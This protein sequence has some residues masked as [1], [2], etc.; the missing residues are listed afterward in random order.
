MPQVD[1]ALLSS[2]VNSF[3]ERVDAISATFERIVGRISPEAT[4]DARANALINPIGTVTGKK[5][6]LDRTDA[7]LKEVVTSLDPAKFAE[8]MKEAAKRASRPEPPQA[9]LDTQV[10]TLKARVLEQQ[11][12]VF[13]AKGDQAKGEA[14]Y[15]EAAKA[16]PSYVPVTL[17]LLDIYTAKSDWASAESMLQASIDAAATPAAKAAPQ[18]RL[19]EVFIK[20][21]DD[22][23]AE[24]LL[25]EVLKS[26]TTLSSTAL[27]SV[28]G[29]LARLEAKRGD[30]AKAL[31]H[32]MAAAAT[33]TLK[34]EDTELMKSLYAKA[35]GGDASGLVKAL[36]KAYLDK[37]PNP[38]KPEEYK[39]TAART[40]KL[41]LLELFTGSGCPPCVASD[42]AMEAV[43]ERYKDHIIPIAYHEH[44]PQ[45]DPMVAVNN[46]DR[47]LWYSVSGVPTFEIDGAM[48]ANAAGTNPGGGGRPNTANVYN[49][50]KTSIDKALELPAR[51]AL[52]VKAT[53]E[54][55]TVSVTVNVTKLP[56]DAKDLKLHIV[57]VEKE[58]RFNGE[59]GIRFHPMAVRSTAGEKGAGLPITTTGSTKYSFSLNQ[60]RD[61]VTKS[62]AADIARRRQSNPAL[63]FAAEGNAYTAIDTHELMVV[64]FIQEGPY[65]APKA[66][67]AQPQQAPQPGQPN[68][69]PA[70]NATPQPGPPT[71]SA[72][73][74]LMNVLNAAKTDV[75]FA[76]AKPKGGK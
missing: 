54:G 55:D 12:R 45:P 66:T 71:A 9:Q 34:A 6:L 70:P 33:G 53:G 32:Y 60:I 37:F 68:V 74:A 16:N 11:A 5:L 38:V 20:K 58:L 21:G 1:S 59:N 24:A 72:D 52:D 8:T 47:R 64:A 35:N 15:K 39:P 13:L 26:S 63:T 44:I 51:A 36:D 17:A 22:A 7:L 10:N 40:N 23:K 27:T 65:R 4:I 56:S 62:L 69:V 28:L 2:L 43:M 31:E 3:P 19:A 46:N 61:E 25:N 30:N 67:P 49:N 42:L 29:P 76:G 75:V 73:P 48:V 14:T 50:Y 18:Q 41:V 57:L